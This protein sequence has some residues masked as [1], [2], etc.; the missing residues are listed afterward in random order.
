M[1]TEHLIDPLSLDAQALA[2]GPANEWGTVTSVLGADVVV[3]RDGR[4]CLAKRAASCLLAPEAGDVVL[5]ARTGDRLFVLAVLERTS[6]HREIEVDG[7]LALRSKNG[8]VTIEGAEAVR[9]RTGGAVSLT[10]KTLTLAAQHASWAS[11]HLR[12]LADNLALEATRIREAAT[13]KESVLDSV[14]ETLGRSYRHIEDAEHVNARTMTF[15]LRE[16][17]RCHAET[18]IHTAKKL[19]KLNADQIHL[20]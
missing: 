1:A 2:L 9:L 7:D 3:S 12:V 14:K 19:V 13:F 17:L 8:T 6:E 10:G 18:A 4:S 5:L 15:S 20:G 11:E 16:T